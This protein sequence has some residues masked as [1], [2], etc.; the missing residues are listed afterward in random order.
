MDLLD[1]QSRDQYFLSLKK[2]PK[3]ISEALISIFS[4]FGSSEVPAFP[5]ATKIFSTRSD[6]EAFQ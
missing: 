2:I 4:A 5:G 6:C 3:S 1:Q